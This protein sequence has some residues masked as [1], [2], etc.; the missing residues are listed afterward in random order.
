[1]DL[2]DPGVPMYCPVCK[3]EYRQGFKTCATCKVALVSQL[4]DEETEQTEYAEKNEP[5][6]KINSEHK[7]SSLV[8]CRE[9]G[10]EI[11]PR[12]DFCP[13]CGIKKS[14][15]NMQISKTYIGVVVVVVLYMCWQLSTPDYRKNKETSDDPIQQELQRENLSQKQDEAEQHNENTQEEKTQENDEQNSDSESLN[16]QIVSFLLNYQPYKHLSK[17]YTATIKDGIAATLAFAQKSGHSAKVA[18]WKVENAG[19]ENEYLV[20]LVVRI[21]GSEDES[22][23]FVDWENKKAVAKNEGAQGIEQVTVITKDMKGK[24]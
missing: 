10:K 7:H 1:M 2:L 20:T 6:E 19:A 24:K 22:T 13:H 23:W 5:P 18:G 12:A 3:G 11:S 14:V 15:L 8:P 9:C 16:N 21:D 17:E 4:P